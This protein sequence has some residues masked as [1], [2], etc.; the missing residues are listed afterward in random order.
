MIWFSI[1]LNGHYGPSVKMYRNNKISY[2][3]NVM[4]CSS[5]GIALNESKKQHNL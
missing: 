5:S 2:N 1:N 4:F 3:A